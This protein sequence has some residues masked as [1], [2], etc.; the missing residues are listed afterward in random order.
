MHATMLKESKIHTKN[1]EQF[2]KLKNS[3]KNE[4]E[5]MVNLNLMPNA[6]GWELAADHGLYIEFD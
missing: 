6:S 4:S 3:N 5:I 2:I 1:N